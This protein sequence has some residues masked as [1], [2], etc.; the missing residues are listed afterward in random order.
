MFITDTREGE[1]PLL[2]EKSLQPLV[3]KNEDGEIVAT[4]TTETAW[5]HQRLIEL[6]QDEILGDHQHRSAINAY[7]GEQWVGSTEV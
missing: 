6:N 7:I 2:D 5:T 1:K 3:F 4:V